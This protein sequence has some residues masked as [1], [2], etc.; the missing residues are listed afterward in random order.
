MYDLIGAKDVVD[1]V[2]K[3]SSLKGMRPQLTSNTQH[4]MATNATL[5]KDEWEQIDER[6]NEVMRERLTIVDDIRARGLVTQVSIG[7][8]LRVTERLEEWRDAEISFDGDTAP[9]EDKT[10]FKQQTIPVP[11]IS[12]GFRI[13]FRQLAASRSRGEPLDMTS[14]A[15]ATRK[16]RDKMQDLFTNGYGQGPDANTIPGLVNADNRLQVTLDTDWDDSGAEIIEDIQK[17][18]AAA[19]AVNLFGPFYLYIP[20][21][22]WAT[23]QGDYSTAKGDRTYMERMLAFNEIEAV[24]PL[25]S[26][27]D[28]NV[29]LVQMTDDVLDMSEAQS[30]TTVQWETTPMVT[31]FRV[32]AIGGPHIKSIET[33]AGSGSTINGIVHLS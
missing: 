7:T 22:Y 23:I 10:S 18:I 13:G 30:I 1:R 25:D 5:R 33:A 28:D 27:S 17:M 14:V 31:E 8:I 19:Y 16:V 4:N 9:K 29:L 11:I 3:V 24:R 26:L 20:T 12:T 21:N 15:S 32:M 2:S 6:V